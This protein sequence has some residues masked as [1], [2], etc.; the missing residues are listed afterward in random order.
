[1]ERSKA[2]LVAK[3]CSQRFGIDYGNTF[4]PVVL[5]LR[6][7]AMVLKLN[8]PIYGLK[9]S[10]KEWYDK[11][12]SVLVNLGFEQCKHEPCLYKSNINNHLVLGAIYVDDLSIGCADKTQVEA[13]KKL[14]SNKFAVTDNGPLHHHLGID[15]KRRR[16]WCY[17]YMP[18]S[19]YSGNAERIWYGK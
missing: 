8:K 10:G 4:S 17:H 19:V 13:V 5:Y 7:P 11:P 6:Q 3:G 12:T 1:M 9:R 14:L 2:R 16:N 18:F 15:R